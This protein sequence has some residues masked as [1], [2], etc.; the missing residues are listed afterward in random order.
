MITQTIQSSTV[1]FMTFE[2][3]AEKGL[4][5]DNLDSEQALSL[6]HSACALSEQRVPEFPEIQ[7]FS[8]K[9]GVLLFCRPLPTPAVSLAFSSWISS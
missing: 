9:D 1:L 8:S 3:L 2:D 5:V 7:L 4:S 6:L